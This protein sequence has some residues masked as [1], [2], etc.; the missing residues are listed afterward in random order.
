[1]NVFVDYGYSKK[2]F[3]LSSE[4]DFH[5]LIAGNCQGSFYCNGSKLEEGTLVLNGAIIHYL[6]TISGGSEI[7]IRTLT[8]KQITIDVQET[9]TISDVRK[10]ISEKDTSAQNFKLY[11]AGKA[12]EEGKSVKDYD[13][14]AES[15]LMMVVGAP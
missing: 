11:Y 9:D 14:S 12:L 8:G 6:P 10:K 2:S 3:A 7:F 1:M 15:V 13:I 5:S 4:Q